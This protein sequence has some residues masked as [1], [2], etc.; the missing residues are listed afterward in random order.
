MLE[1]KSFTFNP[2]QENTYLLY[3]ETKEAVIIDPGCYTEEEKNELDEFISTNKLTVKLLLNTHCHLDHVFG[4][5]HIKNKYKVPLLIHKMDENILRSAPVF[6][7]SYGIPN[8]EP[9]TPD[10][11]IDEEDIIEFG[12]TKLSI[13]FV[14]GHAP[15]HIAFIHEESKKCFSGDVLFFESI[16]RTDLLGGDMNTLISSIKTQLFKLENDTVVYPGH[17]PTTTIGHEKQWN[18]FVKG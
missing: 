14:P 18:P 15:G 16:G 9:S 3:D 4:N 2:F 11:F 13:L 6:A 8:L 12:N 17:G 7:D 10:Q 1:I 5:Q